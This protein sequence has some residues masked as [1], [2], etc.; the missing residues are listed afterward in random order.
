MSKAPAFQ[1]YANDFMDGTR[2]MDANAVGLYIRCICTQWT[3][4]GIPADLPTLARGVNC[5]LH[6]VEKAWPQIKQKFE[7]GPDGLLRNPRLERSRERQALTSA[8][9]SNAAKKRWE[10]VDANASRLHMQG[11]KKKEG[12]NTSSEKERTPERKTLFANCR[13]NAPEAIKEA[14][15]E[16]AQEADLEHYREAI[17]NWSDT[18]DEKRTERGWLATFRQWIKRDRERGELK[19]V[20]TAAPVKSG[21]N[22]RIS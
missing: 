6:E 13:L 4:G 12:I 3:Q 11:K 14:L 21:W 8:G 7:L 10:G 15:P 1:F 22:P 2:F 20:R 18:K 5:E 16:L 17:L 19:T 9:R